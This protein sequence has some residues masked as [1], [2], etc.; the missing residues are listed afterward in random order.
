MHK[1]CTF[2]D[3][4]ITLKMVGNNIFLKILALGFDFHSE[5]LKLVKKSVICRFFLVFI[6]SK[7]MLKCSRFMHVIEPDQIYSRADCE[8]SNDRIYPGTKRSPC[9]VPNKILWMSASFK[10]CYCR[11]GIYRTRFFSVFFRKCSFRAVLFSRFPFYLLFII[12]NIS[13]SHPL[14]FRD[15]HKIAKIKRRENEILLMI[16]S[17]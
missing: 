7:E 5:T 1:T 15:F 6:F 9:L 10:L 4:V 17:K 16:K 11:M 14:Y 13:F 3:D 2:I 8:K 12:S